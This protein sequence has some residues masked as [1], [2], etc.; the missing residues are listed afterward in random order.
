MQL[1]VSPKLL[2]LLL[3]FS[4]RVV[5]SPAQGDQLVLASPP[6]DHAHVVDNDAVWRA[7]NEHPDPVDALVA[8][9]PELAAQLAEPRLLHVFGQQE[10]PVWMTEGDKLRLRRKHQ[11]FMDITD[12]ED[13]YDH[14]KAKPTAG[15]ASTES[16]RVLDT[17]QFFD[18]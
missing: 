6:E 11:K 12:H 5:S 3:S 1:S 9:Q 15:K 2:L 17:D 7:L 8:L 14:T 18:R 4:Q 10:S 13:T 16:P